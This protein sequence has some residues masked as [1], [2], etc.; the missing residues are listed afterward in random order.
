MPRA[1][2]VEAIVGHKKEPNGQFKYFL[3]W[4]GYSSS[5][6]TWESEEDLACPALLQRYWAMQ[7]SPAL[8]SRRNFEIL[9]GARMPDGRLVFAG[10]IRGGE[11]TVYENSYLKENYMEELIDFYLSHLKFGPGRDVTVES[12]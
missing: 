8:V 2:E 1:Y 11:A 4:K 12:R 3:K 9:G 7:R 10:R 6:N 5:H